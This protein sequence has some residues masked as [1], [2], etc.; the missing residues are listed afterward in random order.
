MFDMS[1]LKK[2]FVRGKDA[3]LDH[4]TTRDKSRIKQGQATFTNPTNE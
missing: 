1:P 4:L 3:A 2:V